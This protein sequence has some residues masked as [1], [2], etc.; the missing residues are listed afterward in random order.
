MKTLQD[1]GNKMG[2]MENR[3]WPRIKCDIDAYCTIFMDQWPCK[4][5]DLS[6]RGMGIEPK[7][8]LYMGSIITISDPRVRAKVVWMK[9]DRAG[10][11]IIN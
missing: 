5:I 8:K 7:G 2:Y 1:A 4:I 10:L 6:E 3:M 9:N 11:K